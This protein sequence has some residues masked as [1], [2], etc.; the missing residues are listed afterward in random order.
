MIAYKCKMCGGDLHINAGQT[1]CECDFC[2]TTQTIPQADNDKKA[3]LF[4]RANRLRMTADFDQA[5][6]IYTAITAEFSDEAE[7]F[8]GLC[9]CK[10]GVEYV[11]DPITN[12]KVPTC[13]RT[14][15]SSL[16]SDSDFKKTCEL[17]DPIAKKQYINEAQEIDAIQKE[18]NKIAANESP[19]DVFI[20][21]KEND[22]N[23]N[24]TEDSVLAQDIYD[25]LVS[26]G[27][28]V[29]FARISLEDKLGRQY[30]P[31]IFAALS[32]AKVMLAM[33]SKVEYFNAPW[34]KNE[35]RRFLAMSKN[36]RTKVLIPCFKYIDVYDIPEEL[37]V[38]QA[39]DM[40]KLGWLQDLTRGICKICDKKEQQ[41]KIEIYSNKDDTKDLLQRARIYLDD[42]LWDM[43][44]KYCE[45][46]L[47]IDSKNSQ[48]YWIKLM[49]KLEVHGEYEL[50]LVDSMISN[51]EDYLKALQYANAVER[52]RIEEVNQ[53]IIDNVKRTYKPTLD[54]LSKKIDRA[55]NI[56]ALSS[57]EEQLNSMIQFSEV[58]SLLQKLHR[59]ADT[60]K[61]RLYKESVAL[62]EQ[63]D[64]ERAQ[65]ILED[66]HPYN[67]TEQLLQRCSNELLKIC[68]YAQAKTLVK[69]KEWKEAAA[70][71]ET[72]GD[73]RDSI[74]KAKWCRLHVGI[75]KAARK[76]PS[77]ILASLF[78]TIISTFIIISLAGIIDPNSPFAFLF[79]LLII[80]TPIAAWKTNQL[81]PTLHISINIIVI[82]IGLGLI[83]QF[84][85]ISNEVAGVLILI[86]VIVSIFERV[87]AKRWG[88]ESKPNLP[89]IL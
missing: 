13:H 47:K 70:L 35:W 36:T 22:D 41:G 34:V 17:S 15:M 66:I 71:F 38:F 64:Y 50:K 49:V 45:M 42:G 12:K 28:K 54:E 5:A 58:T 75:D 27:L 56:K 21:Y 3:N 59:I 26:K 86:L 37:S 65:R 39:Q 48:A 77:H 73:Y 7:A 85:G 55:D 63:E 52:K 78:H 44:D 82:M 72:L 14:L 29:F 67:D 33:G 83:G 31:Y 57:I 16:L 79:L 81:K 9:L 76:T 88:K 10:C 69:D 60:I 53:Y 89:R 40:S 43:A 61:E 68:N 87:G 1:I 19:Y 84:Q 20:C 18:I 74:K 46:A 62:V 11:S 8:W 32:S 24:R 23:G 4:N 25:A 80:A 6:L 51:D 2:G 30:E